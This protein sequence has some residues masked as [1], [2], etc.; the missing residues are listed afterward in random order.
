M[1]SRAPHTAADPCVLNGIRPLLSELQEPITL[2]VVPP[3]HGMRP[4]VEGFIHEV[5]AR[6]YGADVRQFHPT[7]L[8][9]RAGPAL[10]AAVGFRDGGD[11]PLFSEHYLPRAAHR[12]IAASTGAPVDAGALVEV[13]NLALAG[14][15]DARWVIAAVTVL[16]HELGYRWVLFTAVK[17]L[18]N[19]FRRLGLNPIPLAAADPAR[20]PGG[21]GAWGRYYQA[22]PV[23]CAGDI[24]AGYHK[25][26]RHVSAQQPALH[27]LLRDAGCQAAGLHTGARALRGGVAR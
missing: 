17:S 10:R 20:L 6:A 7:L 13:G 16:L 12:M 18:V 23:V 19:A 9:L 8:G 2:H 22:R 26:R 11:R 21:G 14:M 24:A 1:H 27:A 25:L 3:A 5:F 15:G 4:A